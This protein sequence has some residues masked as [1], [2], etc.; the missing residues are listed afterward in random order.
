MTLGAARMIFQGS[1]KGNI[2]SNM[3]MLRDTSFLKLV[4]TLPANGIVRVVSTTI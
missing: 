1:I 2:I 3:T 4:P